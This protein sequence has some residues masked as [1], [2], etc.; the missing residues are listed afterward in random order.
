METIDN[1]QLTDEEQTVVKAVEKACMEA[2]VSYLG[3]LATTMEKNKMVAITATD[4]RA[5]AAE[6]AK[7]VPH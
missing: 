1:Q 2:I 4:L 3:D 5:M 6:M 7:R